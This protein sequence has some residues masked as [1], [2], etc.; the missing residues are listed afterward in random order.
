LPYFI[1]IP[2]ALG[3]LGAVIRIKQRISHSYK[4][5]DIGVAGPLAGFVVAIGLLLFGF[6]TLP[7][8]SYILT[9]YCHQSISA[10]IQAYGHFPS[11]LI[12]DIKGQTLVF[13]S[14]LLYGFLASF[15]NN[16]P[17]M[18][19][20]YHYPFLFAGWFGLFVTALNLMP[21]GQLDGGH[22]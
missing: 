19:E 1:P 9:F 3:T 18:W 22:I 14:T 5:F 4:M 7:E 2:F 13:G 12:G 6:A 10:Y 21:V 8:P 15:F 11:E 16:V 17:P 20:M